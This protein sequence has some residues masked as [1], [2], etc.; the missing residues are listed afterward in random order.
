[1]SHRARLQAPGG[2]Q[3]DGNHRV[4]SKEVAMKKVTDLLFS[5]IFADAQLVPF[6]EGMCA[7]GL[8]HKQETM[9]EILFGGS[10][11]KVDLREYHYDL[12]KFRGLSEHHHELMCKHF[13]EVMDELGNVLPAETKTSAI[14]AMRA[15]RTHFR[16]MK[17]GE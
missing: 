10:T 15:Q 17:P 14:A 13:Q 12:I 1:M 16:P 8:R 4:F 9:M 2:I 11:E 3:D 6:F 5:K 7:A